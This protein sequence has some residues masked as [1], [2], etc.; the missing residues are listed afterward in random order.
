MLRAMG[1]P[2]LR[3]AVPRPLRIPVSPP[4]NGEIEAGVDLFWAGLLDREHE[5]TP[6]THRDRRV[7]P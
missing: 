7:H 1:I 5:V 2:H 6:S 4:G 3:L